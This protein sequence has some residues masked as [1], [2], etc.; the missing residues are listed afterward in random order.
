MKDRLRSI[1]FMFVITLVF[2]ALVS[3][4]KARDA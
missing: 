1:L 3:G 4:V 2:T